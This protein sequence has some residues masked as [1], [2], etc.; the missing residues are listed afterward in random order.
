MAISAKQ[1]RQARAFLQQRRITT[2]MISPREFAQSSEELG[3]DFRETL[4]FLKQMLARR[5]RGRIAYEPKE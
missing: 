5:D 4:A 3:K 1:V 2:G